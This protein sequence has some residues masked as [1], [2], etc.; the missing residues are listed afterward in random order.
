M[1]SQA[2]D[3]RGLLVVLTGPSGVGKNSIIEA[4][5]ADDP[6]LFHSVS[7]TTRDPRKGETDGVSYHFASKE[8]FQ[9]LVDAGE[10]LEFDMYCGAYYGTPK[11]PITEKTEHG[12]DVLLDLTVKGAL[13]IR[14]NDPGAVLIFVSAPSEKALRDRLLARGTESPERIEQRLKTARDELNQIQYFDYLVVNNNVEEARADIQAI[15]RAEKR[16]ITRLFVDG[17]EPDSV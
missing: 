8:R 14:K 7:M 5:R 16:R 13:E 9:A 15:I 3:K 10:I 4:L 11:A 1:N 2:A 6:S 12:T 17:S